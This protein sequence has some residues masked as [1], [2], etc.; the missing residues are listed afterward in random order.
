MR[1]RKCQKQHPGDV[2]W[3]IM[4][5]CAHCVE[6]TFEVGV[7]QVTPFEQIHERMHGHSCKGNRRSNTLYLR[8]ACAWLREVRDVFIDL[9]SFAH[10][11]N[12]TNVIRKAL[13]TRSIGVPSVC[14]LH[15]TV[16]SHLVRPKSSVFYFTYTRV[17]RKTLRTR[18]GAF[19]PEHKKTALPARNTHTWCKAWTYI[20]F[21]IKGTTKYVFCIFLQTV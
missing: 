18:K 17:R 13:Q 7:E 20:V 12:Q 5:S 10:T 9:K 1:K 2:S 8:R 6:N 4:I 11:M 16:P 14:I 15:I 21:Y 3:N 19:Y